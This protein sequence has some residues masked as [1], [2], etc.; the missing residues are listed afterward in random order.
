MGTLNWQGI[1]ECE[2]CY[3]LYNISCLNI[4]IFKNQKHFTLGLLEWPEPPPQ[5]L[6]L[7]SQRL[8]LIVGRWTQ[9]SLQ[10]PW[11]RGTEES[12]MT[13]CLCSLAQSGTTMWQTPG[14]A[15]NSLNNNCVISINITCTAQYRL[16]AASLSNEV[17]L[18][19]IVVSVPTECRIH[20]FYLMQ[21]SDALLH[22][23][24]VMQRP[25]IF[26][27]LSSSKP[28]HHAVAR[29]ACPTSA[30]D[31]LNKHLNVFYNEFCITLLKNIVCVPG[32][33]EAGSPLRSHRIWL[34]NIEFTKR[35]LF[36]ENRNKKN[37]I[38]QFHSFSFFSYVLKVPNPTN[39]NQISFVLHQSNIVLF[40]VHIK[41][42]SGVLHTPC[43]SCCCPVLA[44]AAPMV[45]PLDSPF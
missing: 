32:T 1:K 4:L 35:R 44:L 38:F 30:A 36:T 13:K 45:Y 2:T 8:G 29:H 26:N 21:L 27:L 25:G 12:W 5:L 18:S 28:W 11:L 31:I 20:C 22:K 19:R 10:T 17:Q 3:M 6:K 15:N 43:S 16:S 14:R 33:K 9:T 37:Q 40:I 42:T 39:T 7:A 24:L 23:R 41:P 34:R